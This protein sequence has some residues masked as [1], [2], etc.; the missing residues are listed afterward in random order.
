METERKGAHYVPLRNDSLGGPATL[1]RG[2][3][4][5]YLRRRGQ[6]E[7]IVKAVEQTSTSPNTDHGESER[8]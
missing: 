5:R 2:D 4:M 7:A 3:R 1:R 6:N 8:K